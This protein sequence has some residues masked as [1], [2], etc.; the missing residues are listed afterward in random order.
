MT[1]LLC[2]DALPLTGRAGCVHI[3]AWLD[4]QFRRNLRRIQAETDQPI[5]TLV[6]LALND[7]FAKHGLPPVLPG[8]QAS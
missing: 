6:A 3:G 5:Q 8:G 4:P 1:K 2:G 7:L